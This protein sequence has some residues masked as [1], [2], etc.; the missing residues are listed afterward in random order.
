MLCWI[1]H[2]KSTSNLSHTL[3]LEKTY[4]KVVYTKQKFVVIMLIK[5]KGPP[6]PR[7][8]FHLLY[9]FLFHKHMILHGSRI[10]TLQVRVNYY[11]EPTAACT[12]RTITTGNAVIHMSYTTMCGSQPASKLPSF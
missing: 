6:L 12:H 9:N 3:G 2:M 10:Q 8:T 1:Y 11:S 4:K 7:S 5:S